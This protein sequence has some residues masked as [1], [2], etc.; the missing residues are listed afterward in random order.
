MKHLIHESDR[1]HSPRCGLSERLNDGSVVDG[2]YSFSSLLHKEYLQ[3]EWL[4]DGDFLAQKQQT[5][6]IDFGDLLMM[7]LSVA[8][9]MRIS[10]H[11]DVLE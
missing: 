10:Y 8:F 1:N 11:S 7:I 6:L 5:C 2:R 9:F 3:C 4:P